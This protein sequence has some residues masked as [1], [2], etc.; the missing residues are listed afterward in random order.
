MNHEI[1]RPLRNALTRQAVGDVHP[2][3][4]VL[5]SFME[6]TLPPVENEV[7]THHLAQ[8]ADCREIVFLAREA[9]KDEVGSERELVAAASVRRVAAPRA[10]AEIPVLPDASADTSRSGS[11][12]RMRWAMSIAAVALVVSGGLV[13]QYSRARNAD[14]AAP[15]TIASNH[16]TAPNQKSQEPANPANPQDTSPQPVVPQSIAKGTPPAPIAP[17]HTTVP[18]PSVENRAKGFTPTAPTSNVNS[19]PLA[20]SAPATPGAVVGGME[21]ALAPAVRPQSSFAESEAGQVLQLQQ[22]APVMF[23][24]ASMGNA[25]SEPMPQWRISPEGHLERSKAANQWAR[26]LDDQP[27]TFRVVSVVANDVWAGGNSGT[28]FHSADRGRHW[29][30]VSLAAN[31]T[32]ETGAIVSIRFEDSQRGVVTTDGGTRW[33]TT[34]G[35]LTWL[36]Q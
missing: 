11:T 28:L 12:S 20:P 5:T 27:V 13:L 6:R 18:T 2:T 25:L 31:S 29:N 7:V 34:D 14:K 33:T 22:G 26:V 21:N 30:K 15:I 23:G 16:P 9:T 17:R 35:G 36:T 19:P 3:P 10:Y 4:D 1:P 8:C 24:K 32:R